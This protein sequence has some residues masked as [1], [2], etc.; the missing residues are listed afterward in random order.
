MSTNAGGLISE[1]RDGYE[2]L[3]STVGLLRGDGIVPA[4]ARKVR[5]GD[6]LCKN[7]SGKFEVTRYTQIAATAANGQPVVQ[8]DDAHAFKAGDVVQI[9]DEAGTHTIDS[10]DYDTNEITLTTNLTG[11]RAVDKYV[12]SSTAALAKTVAIHIGEDLISRAYDQTIAPAFGGNFKKSKIR[13]Y[14]TQT[15][16]DL[17]G[18]EKDTF[19]TFS[20]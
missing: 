19:D 6:V 1:S 3:Q 10:I 8:V 13:G 17:D 9:E 15:K 5:K 14:Y 20:F 16:T 7:A 12:K 11:E 4:N 2:V 18:T